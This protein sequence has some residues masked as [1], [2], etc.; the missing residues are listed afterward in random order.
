MNHK[1][2]VKPLENVSSPEIVYLFFG[3]SNLAD[4][5]P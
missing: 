4:F 1:T 5:I 2:I 3:N